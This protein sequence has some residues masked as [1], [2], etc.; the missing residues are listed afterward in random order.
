MSSITPVTIVPKLMH[1]HLLPINSLFTS[2]VFI[3]VL[4]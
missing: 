2:V 4:H 3:V 1:S